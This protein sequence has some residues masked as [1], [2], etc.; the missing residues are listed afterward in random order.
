MMRVLWFPGNGALYSNTNKYNGGGW[1]GALAREI[2]ETHPEI[3]LGMAIP[4]SCEMH[5]MQQGVEFF[6]IPKIRH[7]FIGYD[8]KLQKQVQLMKSIVDKFQPDVI[9]IFGSEH[10]SGLVATITDVPVVLH[11]QGI[12]TFLEM[13][14]LPYNMSWEKLIRWKP[15]QFINRK[16]LNRNCLTEQRIFRSCHHYMGRTDMDRR[17]INILSPNCRYYYCSEMLRPEIYYSEKKW[18]YHTRSSHQ[19]VSVI[20]SPFYKGGDVILRAAKILKEQMHLDFEWSVY[21]VCDMKVWERLVG[22]KASDVNV[23]IRGVIDAKGLVDVIT[24]SDVFVHPSYIENSPNTVCEAQVLGI[25]VIANHVG[26]I[27]SLIKSGENG[28]L[29]PANDCYMTASYIKDLCEDSTFAVSI[30]ENG[31]STAQKRHSPLTIVDD[32]INVYNAIVS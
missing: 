30:G 14:W 19:I 32:V 1:T 10:T 11:L 31:M 28:I 3:R 2:L 29:L 27:A 7:A 26:G 20:S 4:W 25:P 13:A 6:G 8:R 22:I 5:D 16:G 21:G 12:L 17:V 9:H 15:R 23:S 24:E 18:T